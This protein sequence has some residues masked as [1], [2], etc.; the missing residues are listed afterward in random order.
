MPI[1]ET[2]SDQ[3]ST[4][5]DIVIDPLEHISLCE[6]DS[7]RGA[8]DAGAHHARHAKCGN[9]IFSTPQSRTRGNGGPIE[10]SR[11]AASP[12][13]PAAISVK[14]QIAWAADL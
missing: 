2:R 8:K 13:P 1:Q 7:V 6:C 11:V 12:T 4:R 9:A 14:G 3:E 10:T 5:G